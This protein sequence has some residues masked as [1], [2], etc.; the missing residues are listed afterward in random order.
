MWSLRLESK[1]VPPEYVA[2]ISTTLNGSAEYYR[3]VLEKHNGKAMR[4]P[5]NV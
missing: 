2:G 3:I 4:I 5:C 1:P